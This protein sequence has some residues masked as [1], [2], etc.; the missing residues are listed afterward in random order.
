[1]TNTLKKY[2][3]DTNSLITPYKTY[4]P[5][6]FAEKFWNQLE[7]E[8]SKGRLVVLDLVK[9]ELAKGDDELSEWI[10]NISSSLIFSHRNPAIVAKYGEVLTHLQIS[11]FY[12]EKALADWARADIAD[13]WL[14]ATAAVYGYTIITFETPNGNLN[15]RNK[16]GRA[17]IP[18]VSTAFGVK[19]ENLYYMMRQLSFTM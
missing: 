14:I 17:K 3:I 15:T 7:G 8:I 4:Y 1:M 10:K 9:A 16:S 5:F 18:D 6:D 19:C 12:K 2:L 13:A 11:G